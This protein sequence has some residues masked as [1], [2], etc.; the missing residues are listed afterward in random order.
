MG[1]YLSSQNTQFREPPMTIGPVPAKAHIL[2]SL[3]LFSADFKKMRITMKE[4]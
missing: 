1:Q 3:V 4:K 2:M